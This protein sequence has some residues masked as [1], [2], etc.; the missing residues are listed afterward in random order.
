[1]NEGRTGSAWS[2]VSRTVT[3]F[4]TAT[5][6]TPAAFAA[7]TPW[8]ESSNAMASSGSVRSAASAAR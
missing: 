2:K 4:G 8:G 6:Q 5:H 7:V 3:G 1:M